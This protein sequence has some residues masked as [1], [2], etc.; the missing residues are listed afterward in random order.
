LSVLAFARNQLELLYRRPWRSL[1]ALLCLALLGLLAHRSFSYLEA[2]YLEPGRHYRRALSALE[3]RDFEEARQH[4][5]RCL[6]AC[7]RD[8]RYEF[9]AARAARRSG[10]LEEAEAH[11]FACQRLEE[12]FGATPAGDTKLEWALLQV[13]RGQLVDLEP[14]L[15][16]RL[17]EDHPDSLL[18]WEALSWELM[19]TG[20]YGEALDCLNQWL[21]R[22]PEDYEALV[23]RAWVAEH[24]LD[25]AGALA[26]YAKALAQ[27]PRQDH[28]RLHVAEILV[29]RNRAAEALSDLEQLRARQPNNMAV[30]LC[31]ARALRQVNRVEESMSVLDNLLASHPGDAQAMSERGLVAL[32]MNRPTEAERLLRLAADHDPSNRQVNYNLYQCLERLNKKEEARRLAAELAQT[33]EQVKR[34]DQLIRGVMKKPYDPVLRYRVGLIFLQNNFTA[35]GLRW[36]DTALKVDP[37]HRPTHEALA[38]YYERAGD[39]SQA[40]YHRQFLR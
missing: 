35:D 32:A 5:A 23:R 26:D 27:D 39:Q 36:L 22:R 19:W 31:W 33:D 10:N 20:R 30:A 34:L 38:R 18:I 21:Q 12:T 13:Q 17:R 8:S 40:E 28:V 4:L 7:P 37:Q 16:A 11:L 3:R 6:E 29:E 14:Y 24:L 1:G 9:L 15:R 25:F 2:Q